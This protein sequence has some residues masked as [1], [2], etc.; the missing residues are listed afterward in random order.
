MFFSGFGIDGYVSELRFWDIDG[1]FIQDANETV[2]TTTDSTGFYELSGIAPGVGQI[3]IKNDGVDTN[4]GGSVGMMAA[5]TNVEDSENANVTSHAFKA[6]GISEETIVA[7]LGVD[8]SI[9]SYNPMA[10]LEGSSDD[11]E[12]ETAGTVLLKAQQL[13]GIVN[14]VAGLAEESGLSAAEALAETVSAIG[15]Q[16]LSNFVG[17]D[18]GD[19]TTLANII[20]QVAPDFASVAEAA[21]S[22]LKNVKAV[23]GETLANPK[24]DLVVDAR[25]QPD[26][27]R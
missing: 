13:F 18:G 10:I 23:F 2:E 22:S 16:D 5:S 17:E 26:K 1:D 9:D 11:T 27:T 7:A 14:S 25:V 20:T 24:K 8:V 21:A 15:G 6:Q 12:L 3:V 4:T 19:Q